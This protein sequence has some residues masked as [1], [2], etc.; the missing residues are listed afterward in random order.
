MENNQEDPRDL[1]RKLKVLQNTL[2]GTD[3]DKFPRSPQEAFMMW[4][5]EAIAA[6]VQEPH[7]MTLSTVDDYGC[8]DARVL[9]LKNVDERGWHFAAKAGS[10]KG[11]QLVNKGYAALTFYW[12]EQARQVRLR[13]KAEQLSDE[14]CLQDFFDRP[15]GSR[16]SAMASKQS[17]KLESRAELLGSVEAVKASFKE[18][19]DQPCVDWKVYAVLPETVE[20]WQGTADRLHERLQYVA[21]GPGQWETQLLWP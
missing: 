12:P 9:I 16:V 6:E 15:L 18:N 3:F 7:A 10:P 8:P 14:E 11:V 20:F 13:G 17:S 21:A 19:P 4:L 2:P 1:L 5:K